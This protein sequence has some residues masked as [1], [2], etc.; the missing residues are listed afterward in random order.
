MNVFEKIKIFIEYLFFL[1]LEKFI[2]S[3]ES[4][5]SKS[6]LF[7][8]TGQIGDLIVSSL[9][10][11]NPDVFEEY[12]KVEFVIKE[13]Y[14]AL[15][16]DYCGKIKFI[17]YNPK[18][19]KLFFPYKVKFLDYI[20]SVGFEKCIN[21]TAARGIINDEL[22]LLSGAKE[23][24]CLNNNNKFLGEYFGKKLE[25][26]Y[27][28]ILFAEITNE[29]D[30][31]KELLKKLSGE[32]NVKVHFFN[33]LT[34]KTNDYSTARDYINDN[35]LIIVAPLSSEQNRDWSQNHFTQLLRLLSPNYSI[36][37][38]GTHKQ[39]RSLQKIQS[40]LPNVVILAGE[41]ELNN[42]TSLLVKAKLFIGLDSGL[43]H[44][45]LKLGIPLVAIIGGGFYQNFFPFMKSVKVKYLY[46]KMDCFGCE[47]ECIY[48]KK[49][50][51][52]DITVD[53]VFSEI[54]KIL[55]LENAK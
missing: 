34:F 47:W 31:H 5:I 14:L 15:F 55:Q 52:E 41:L 45:V 1:I 44:L 40:D 7:I 33:R 28:N 18:K 36:I 43:T 35:G 19:H 24:Y 21:L 13:Q 23:K 29:Y 30:K 42:L 17:G 22:T 50:C 32:N 54:E 25:R 8:N 46:S 12:E 53:E 10:L 3:K 48:D 38:L 2:V 11:E 39:K 37:L 16:A 51:I 9:L 27:T 26:K 20:R 6:I 49:H 4:S